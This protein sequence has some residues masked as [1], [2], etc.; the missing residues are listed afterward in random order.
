MF[1]L[2]SREILQWIVFSYGTVAVCKAAAAL[3]LRP[4]QSSI[5]RISRAIRLSPSSALPPNF[6]IALSHFGAKHS[7]SG[8]YMERSPFGIRKQSV[9]A[10]PLGN[11]QSETVAY[12]ARPIELLAHP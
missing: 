10:L 7:L 2:R 1:V 4:E 12:C 11:R 5:S 6:R 8:K 9:L 3:E